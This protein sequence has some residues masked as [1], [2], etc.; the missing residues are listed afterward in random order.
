MQH[1]KQHQQQQQQH[2]HQQ[3]QQ[4]L[5]KSHNKSQ[6]H[7]HYHPLY[8][9]SQQQQQA[10][11]TSSTAASVNNDYYDHLKRLDKLALGLVAEQLHPWHNDKS[12]LESLNSDYFKNSLHQ[13][14]ELK[15]QHFEIEAL[16]QAVNLLTQEK[17]R[18]YQSRRQKHHSVD[19]NQKQ[20]HSA[21]A[22]GGESCPENSQSSV[23]PE[24]TTSNS[25]DQSDSG[26]LSEQEYDIT[27]IEEIYQKTHIE[28]DADSYE[29]ISLT[30]TTR[31]RFESTGD[32]CENDDDYDRNH[33]DECDYNEESHEE[34]HQAEEVDQHTTTDT[35]VEG[36]LK[37]SRAV[38]DNLQKII[39]YD[40]V[41]L[42]SEESSDSTLVDTDH[43][44]TSL[45]VTSLRTCI[46]EVETVLHISIEDAIYE[47]KAKQNKL[48]LELED[49]HEPISFVETVNTKIEILEEDSCDDLEA[50]EVAP[51]YTQILKV[52]HTPS[53]V[54]PHSSVI[55][56]VPVGV[57]SSAASKPKILSVV[58]KRKLKRYSDSAYSSNVSDSSDRTHG[59]YPSNE[60]SAYSHHLKRQ[61]AE[62]LYIPLRTNL[63]DNQYHSLPDVNIGQI[64]KVSESI[65]AQLRSCYNFDNY[66][67][68]D[69]PATGD[70]DQAEEDIVENIGGIDSH[71]TDDHY[72]INNNNSNNIR[73]KKREEVVTSEQIYDSIKRF[74][75]AHQRYRQKEIKE[76]QQ[77]QQQHQQQ[78]Q[79]HHHQQNNQ[80]K[81]QTN[82]DHIE[83]NTEI[84]EG[85]Y[86]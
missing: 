32:E 15:Q 22:S 71:G 42:S 73:L 64:L 10:G 54:V 25:D 82:K 45:E 8:H 46:D 14:H 81:E 16:E 1:Y 21:G 39:A 67:S 52:E 4:Q 85:K 84:D 34:D 86:I 20:P 17:P 76:C 41:Y 33:L 26:S 75:R 2:L 49:Q 19:N 66:R 56:T 74:G 13:S 9:D 61:V 28:G 80:P 44:D 6:Q 24:T 7:L 43:C 83:V 57:T 60:S 70:G 36:T 12:D 58:E 50:E 23:F 30:T 62:P 53:S 68:L 40:S 27:K 78:Q 65:D 29:I 35:E 63:S 18:I 5:Q 3:Q 38:S 77:Q 31:T 11:P 47:P 37:R 55:S 79:Q 59:S 69:D 48:E 51:V 72:F